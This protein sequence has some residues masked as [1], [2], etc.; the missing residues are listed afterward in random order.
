VPVQQ[1]VRSQEQAGIAQAPVQHGGSIVGA[2]D[3][4]SI[5]RGLQLLPMRVVPGWCEQE[6]LVDR[7]ASRRA[8]M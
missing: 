1:R 4:S 3:L 8:G 7:Y 6:F 5:V 2:A